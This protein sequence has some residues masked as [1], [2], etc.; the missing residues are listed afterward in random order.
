M[1]RR[2]YRSPPGWLETPRDALLVEPWRHQKGR[3]ALPTKPGLGFEIDRKA[4][5]RYGA[6]FFTATQLRVA[7]RAIRDRGLAEARAIGAARRRRLAQREIELAK[8]RD[9]SME[10]LAELAPPPDAG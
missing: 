2:V 5:G 6:R 7:V 3:L 9:P 10:A 1:R 4:L 8:M